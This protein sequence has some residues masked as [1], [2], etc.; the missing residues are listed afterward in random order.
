MSQLNHSPSTDHVKILTG[1][2]FSFALS[3]LIRARS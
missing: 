3:T 2:R 1:E